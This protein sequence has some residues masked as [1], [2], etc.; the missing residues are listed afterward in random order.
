M[1]WYD[2][3]LHETHRCKPLAAW[4]DAWRDGSDWKTAFMRKVGG[5]VAPPGS[6]RRNHP[7]APTHLSMSP[8]PCPPFPVPFSLPAAFMR[9]VGKAAPPGRKFRPYIQAHDDSFYPSHTIPKPH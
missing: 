1:G 2:G 3:I 7:G 4:V 8:S 6:R 5:P 9:K